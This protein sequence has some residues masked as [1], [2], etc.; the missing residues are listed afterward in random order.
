MSLYE[1]VI[2]LEAAKEVGVYKGKK[3]QVLRYKH[4][5]KVVEL[6]WFSD[7]SKSFRVATSKVQITKPQKKSY[8]K[9][10]KHKPVKKHKPLSSW[11]KKQT[12]LG[13]NIKVD[14]KKKIVDMRKMPNLN[15]AV[16]PD[17][18]YEAFQSVESDLEELEAA[19]YKIL[20][21]KH[22]A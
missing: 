11:L 19:G 21:P 7:K 8:S 17:L 16:Q 9:S 22:Y 2:L 12:G 3:Y 5:G 10:K 6:A 13:W 1:R 14:H 15:D 20:K 4:G 18:E